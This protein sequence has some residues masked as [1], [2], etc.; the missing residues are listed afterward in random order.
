MD[1]SHFTDSLRRALLF[2]SI[3]VLGTVAW[4]AL[5]STV[6]AQ[7]DKVFF[8]AEPFIGARPGMG[9]DTST[10]SAAKG[11]RPC[12]KVDEQQ[13]YDQGD[14]RID[15]NYKKVTSKSDISKELKL[16]AL[17]QYKS[18]TGA[19]E[20]NSNLEMV[21]N[22]RAHEYSETNL[23]YSYK[24]NNTRM[25]K[26]EGISLLEDYKKLLEKKD[27][28]AKDEFR[29]KCGNAFVVGTKTGSYYLGS[30]FK[31]FSDS[32]NTS[33]LKFGFMFAMELSGKAKIQANFDRKQIEELER[34][35]IEVQRSSS[36][37]TANPNTVKELEDQWKKFSEK[38][39]EGKLVQVTLAPYTVANGTPP[40]TILDQPPNLAKLETLLGAL[41]DLKS[42]REEAGFILRYKDKFALGIPGGPT[43]EQ[44]LKFVQEAS[45]KLV[46]ESDRLLADVKACIESFTP[47]CAKLAN[48]YESHPRISLQA[49]FPKKYRSYCYGNFQ[50]N[51]AR[52]QD[53]EPHFLLDPKAGEGDVDWGPVTLSAW[54]D[55]KPS[56]RLLEAQVTVKEQ[57]EGGDSTIMG[58]RQSF[59]IF[60][61]DLQFDGSDILFNECEFDM[62]SPIKNMKVGK[63]ELGAYGSLLHQGL[64]G[65]NKGNLGKWLKGYENASGL[66]KSIECQLIFKGTDVNNAKCRYPDIKPFEVNLV[67]REDK[68]AESWKRPPLPEAP[69]LKNINTWKDTPGAM[70]LI[71][72]KHLQRDKAF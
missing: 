55:F 45:G 40:E 30:S 44:R 43:R 68:T 41:W 65:K 69:S 24:L 6:W 19:Y 29:A 70:P 31:E 48:W 59:E 64:G 13:I 46:E 3:L 66:L 1:R 39:G 63:A 16:S 42:L 67:N 25:H 71:Q 58:Q 2:K 7:S 23:Y 37:P 5:A 38:N 18:L 57:Q 51:Q 52:F 34:E 9:Y 62:S 4:S 49:L 22:T 26:T 14:G 15:S 10:M 11:G 50:V 17:A 54:L 36:E 28:K 27:V 47:D 60:N 72:D 32:T 53:R 35:K 20:A 8:E 12:V 21:E 61:L 56:P 33:S